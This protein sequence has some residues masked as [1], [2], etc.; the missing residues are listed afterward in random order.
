MSGS[1][2]GDVT[3]CISP[4]R[5]VLPGVTLLVGCRA[6][7]PVGAGGPQGVTT[8]GWPVRPLRRA[9]SVGRSGTGSGPERWRSGTGSDPFE[10]VSGRCPG[11]AR[12]RWGCRGRGDGARLGDGPVGTE[13]ALVGRSVRREAPHPHTR[14]PQGVTLAAAS[15]AGVVSA[16]DPRVGRGALAGRDAATPRAARNVRIAVGRCDYLRRSWANCA[17]GRHIARGM[18]GSGGLVRCAHPYTTERAGLPKWG[19]RPVVSLRGQ[20]PGRVAP[21]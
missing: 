14:R 4:G 1:P 12:C 20:A 5:I 7:G 18:Q 11:V 16:P 6:R 13:C 21:A 3:T 2:W 17:V 15:A 10:C 19:D 9:R 8:L